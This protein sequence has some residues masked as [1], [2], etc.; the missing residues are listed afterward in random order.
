MSVTNY[1][2]SVTPRPAL[3]LISG[4]LQEVPAA[5]LG[6]GKLPIVVMPNGT[7]RERQTTEGIPLI[8]MSGVLRQLNATETL[9]I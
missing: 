3:V 8:L 1:I 9:Q 7:I 2:V 6:T 4:L 5:L